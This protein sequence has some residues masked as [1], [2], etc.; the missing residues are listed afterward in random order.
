MCNFCFKGL[1][2]PL[3]ARPRA[4]KAM[5]KKRARK[6]DPLDQA[7]LVEPF[8]EFVELRQCLLCGSAKKKW[9]C[10]CEPC[11]NFNG[12]RAKAK[13]WLKMFRESPN[14]LRP[15]SSAASIIRKYDLRPEDLRY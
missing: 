11:A 1:P 5:A 13:T 3:D 7:R 6:M 9:S 2:H 10:F 14:N 8:M 4:V 12:A 15:L